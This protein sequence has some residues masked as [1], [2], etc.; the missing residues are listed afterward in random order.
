MLNCLSLIVMMQIL[1]VIYV[2]EEYVIEIYLQ[3]FRMFVDDER[4]AFGA[5]GVIFSCSCITL[6]PFI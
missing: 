3:Y 2:C 5:R 1:G 6:C 4:I